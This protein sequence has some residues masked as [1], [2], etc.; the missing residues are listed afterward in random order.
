M[1]KIIK[2]FKS[3]FVISFITSWILSCAILT[4]SIPINSVRIENTKVESLFQQDTKV[5]NIRALWRGNT[6]EILYDFSEASI[7]QNG[8]FTMS[9]YSDDGNVFKSNIGDG[10]STTG[11]IL[12][13]DK[14][15]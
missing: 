14:N 3:A 5:Q 6:I 11:S 1:S 12:S 8:S 2:R 13:L 15:T 10:L 4:K 9:Y 7:S